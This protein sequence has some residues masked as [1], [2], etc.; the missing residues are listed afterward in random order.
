MMGAAFD[1]RCIRLLLTASTVR[2]LITQLETAWGAADRP[3]PVWQDLL[4]AGPLVQMDLHDG[5][6]GE[7]VLE[8]DRS[9]AKMKERMAFGVVR[10]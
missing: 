6:Y 8:G 1:N 7:F 5:R 2:D 3:M 9:V 4:A 10:F